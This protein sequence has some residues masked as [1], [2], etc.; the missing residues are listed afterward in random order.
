MKG[1]VVG[2]KKGTGESGEL[3]KKITKGGRKT[4]E[5]IAVCRN[6]YG[7]EWNEQNPK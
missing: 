6:V 1:G 5:K 4:R 2:K 3:G 7:H